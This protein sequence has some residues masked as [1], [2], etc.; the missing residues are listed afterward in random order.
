MFK[1]SRLIS[2]RNQPLPIEDTCAAGP[3]RNSPP[4]PTEKLRPATGR[5]PRALCSSPSLSHRSLSL[6]IQMGEQ[7][8]TLSVTTSATLLLLSSSTCHSPPMLKSR[9]GGGAHG[10]TNRRPGATH[11]WCCYPA[12]LA[13]VRGMVLCN[14]TSPGG[15]RAASRHELLHGASEG[16]WRHPYFLTSP[17]AAMKLL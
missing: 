9:R 11:S 6:K 8:L 4:Y 16:Q 10:A 3:A 1:F 17:G 15:R 2:L 14:A 12:H 13:D 5:L 7:A